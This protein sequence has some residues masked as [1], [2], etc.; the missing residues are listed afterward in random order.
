VTGYF[1]LPLVL[2]KKPLDINGYFL[3]RAMEIW[4]LPIDYIGKKLRLCENSGQRVAPDM[5]AIAP[6]QHCW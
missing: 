3:Q 5:W 2:Y 6:R 1:Q 4:L